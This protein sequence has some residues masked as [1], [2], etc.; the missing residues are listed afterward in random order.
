MLACLLSKERPLAALLHR[1]AHIPPLYYY[2]LICIYFLNITLEDAHTIS[3]RTIS[4]NGLVKKKILGFLLVQFKR[5]THLSK[6]FV[7][8]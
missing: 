8:L 4:S 3:E 7:E 2:F 1:H 6:V 5:I